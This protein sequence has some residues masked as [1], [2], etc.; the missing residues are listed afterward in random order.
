MG[1][2]WWRSF[3]YL[4]DERVDEVAD[5]ADHPVRGEEHRAT[6]DEERADRRAEDRAADEP[7]VDREPE[8]HRDD[9]HDGEDEEGRGRQQ[10]D[11]GERGGRGRG[12]EA[13]PG[14]HLQLRAVRRSPRRPGAP[15]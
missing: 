14:E 5:A 10:P 2:G 15:G 3:R 7:R 13:G 8:E 11:G 9:G 1:G 4:P 6:R 12:V